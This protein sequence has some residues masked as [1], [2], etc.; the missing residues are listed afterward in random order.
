[1]RMSGVAD[2]ECDVKRGYRK[3]TMRQDVPV[4]QPAVVILVMLF[5]L[6]VSFNRAPVALHHELPGLNAC[7]FL[8][9]KGSTVLGQAIG[10]SGECAVVHDAGDSHTV[11]CTPWMVA[12][13][14]IVPGLPA[15]G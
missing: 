8:C 9:L 10:L 4:R 1:M 3:G 14:S 7:R 13:G 6:V 5:G 12:A 2:E 11:H 15:A